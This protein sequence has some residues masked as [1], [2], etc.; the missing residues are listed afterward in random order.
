MKAQYIKEYIADW[1][2]L[3]LIKDLGGDHDEYDSLSYDLYIW[4]DKKRDASE[5]EIAN[6]TIEL[7]YDWTGGF[8]DEL[9]NEILSRRRDIREALI[10]DCA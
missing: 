10:K 3:G 7:L 6:K 9:K 2:P 5:N 4:F 1:D 8:S